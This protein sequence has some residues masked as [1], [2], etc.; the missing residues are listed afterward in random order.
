MFL[1]TQGGI[2]VV[3]YH[4]SQ[5]LIKKPYYGGGRAANLHSE[6][7]AGKDRAR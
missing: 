7:H 1:K 4:G 6:N 3:L 5:N 2:V